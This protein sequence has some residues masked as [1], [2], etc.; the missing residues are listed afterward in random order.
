MKQASTLFLRIVIIGIGAI[1]AFFCILAMSVALR[2]D[3][4]DYYKPILICLSIP[5]IPFFIAL[6]QSIK[7]LNLIDAQK[8]FSAMSVRAFKNIRNCALII[9]GLFAVGM[10]LFYRAA[11]QDDAPGVIVIGLIIALASFVIATFSAVLQKLVQNA[12]DIKHENDLTV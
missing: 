4:T 8:A 12:V 7:I 10:P 2:S 3:N 5:A 6:W 9:S 1:M 11:D